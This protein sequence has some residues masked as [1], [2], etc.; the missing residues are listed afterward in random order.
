MFEVEVTGGWCLLNCMCN[1]FETRNEK[2][3][4]FYYTIGHN[5]LNMVKTG[6]LS[7]CLSNKDERLLNERSLNGTTINNVTWMGSLYICPCAGED[8][9]REALISLW[10]NYGNTV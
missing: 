10:L 9:N 4:N 5:V 3:G 2:I 1:M 8:N 7:L 6:Y